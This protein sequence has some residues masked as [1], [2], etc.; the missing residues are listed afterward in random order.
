MLGVEKRNGKKY[1]FLLSTLIRPHLPSDL[2][3]KVNVVFWNFHE[4]YGN[5]DSQF[6]RSKI[7]RDV[8]CEVAE[9]MT[10]E[11]IFFVN[12]DPYQYVVNSY[13]FR[14][15]NCKVSG[16]MLSLYVRRAK[17]GGLK[18]AFTTLRKR[19][20]LYWMTLNRNVETVFVLND[21]PVAQELN[22]E[23]FFP[24]V[25]DYLPD[26]VNIDESIV[27]DVPVVDRSDSETLVLVAGAISPRKNI[28]RI[29]SAVSRLSGNYRLLL[30]GKSSA[31]FEEEI[32]VHLNEKSH[33][34]VTRVNRF[35]TDAELYQFYQKADVVLVPY[36]NFYA[37][38]GVL[39][40]AAYFGKPV[41]CGDY[42]LMGELTEEFNLGVLVDV[43]KVSSI[44]EGILRALK[45]KKIYAVQ[46]L[47][48][49]TVDAFQDKILN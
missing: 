16:I 49:H 29:I 14:R 17:N 7:D 34:K 12:M 32:K 2:L 39:N 25:F 4:L 30:I 24:K 10:L 9:E 6:K 21:K 46:Y 43:W 13:K 27:L 8:I 26:P 36:L 42:G 19:F 3:S 44:S 1:T 23:L 40:M 35:V 15:L 48:E 28:I 37:S 11:S 22:N 31:D 47:A 33:L 41:V 38:S 45:S 18:Q 5:I 20:Q